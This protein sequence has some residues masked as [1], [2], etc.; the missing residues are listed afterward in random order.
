MIGIIA[1]AVSEKVKIEDESKTEIK[2]AVNANVKPPNP[3][4]EL[5]ECELEKGGNGKLRGHQLF[6]C[7]QNKGL[8]TSL[9]ACVLDDR[10]EHQKTKSGNESCNKYLLYKYYYYYPKTHMA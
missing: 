3:V 10:K 2:P 6:V 4:E 9:N 8:F 7:P 5:K 1:G